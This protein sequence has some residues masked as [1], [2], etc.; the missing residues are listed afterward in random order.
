FPPST[1][2][3]VTY[4]LFALTVPYAELWR[5]S[6][7]ARNKQVF[8]RSIEVAHIWASESQNSGRNPSGNIYFDGPTIYSYG[9]HYALAHIYHARGG[10]V[11]VL[12]DHGYSMTTQGHRCDVRAAVRDTATVFS[13]PEVRPA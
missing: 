11:V 4:C 8:A 2:S 5:V 9:P 7:M 10:R 12:N 3:P 13:C 1:F 6:P